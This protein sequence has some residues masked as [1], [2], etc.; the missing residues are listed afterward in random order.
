MNAQPETGK[1]TK[2]GSKFPI[3]AKPELKPIENKAVENNPFSK[4]SP[5]KFDE[6]LYKPSTD[7]FQEKKKPSFVIGEN[8]DEDKNKN[9]KFVNPDKKMIDVLNKKFGDTDLGVFICNSNYIIIGCRDHNAIDGDRV[10]I[11]HNRKYI[12]NNIILASVFEQFKI[13]LEVG[14]N[15]IEFLALNEGEGFPNTAE[16]EVR[17]ESGKVIF[18]N[19]WDLSTGSTGRLIITKEK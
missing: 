7:S 9:N 2:I 14:E 4:K 19:R 15:K 13:V 12:A 8:R 18:T 16:F 1:K 10:A 17:D 6:P 11:I 3:V 5:L